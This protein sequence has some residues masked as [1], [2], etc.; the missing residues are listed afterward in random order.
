MIAVTG[1]FPTSEN[2]AITIRESID[3][4]LAKLPWKVT[5]SKHITS[6]DDPHC[7]S[8]IRWLRHKE[9]VCLRKLK[10]SF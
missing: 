4:S 8:V 10:E 1:F 3:G 6:E 2:D 5:V 7:F 9:S